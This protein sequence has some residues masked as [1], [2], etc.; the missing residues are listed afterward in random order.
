MPWEHYIIAAR[1]LKAQSFMHV[2]PYRVGGTYPGQRIVVW[3]HDN[4]S[5]EE[6][7]MQPGF[8]VGGYENKWLKTGIIAKYEK[9]APSP[10]GMTAAEVRGMVAWRPAECNMMKQI[11]VGFS[12]QCW[13][14]GVE[15]GGRKLK[16][17]G[18]YQ[19]AR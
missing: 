7:T 18:S 17:C 12:S 3:A 5:M 11:M 19:C 16:A 15:Q 13:G 8:Q 6:R 14:C 9:K 4:I 10:L 2:A 1:I